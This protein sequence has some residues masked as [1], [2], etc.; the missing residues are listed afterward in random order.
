MSRDTSVPSDE[1]T[2]QKRRQLRREV[3]RILKA[4]LEEDGPGVAVLVIVN[5]NIVLSEGYGYA[6]IGEPDGKITADTVFDLASL[7]KHFTALGILMLIDRTT[8]GNRPDDGSKYWEL[9]F[10][11]SLKSILTELPPW[12][13][14]ITIRHLLN[15]TSGIPDYFALKLQLNEC[16]LDKYF[17]K[18]CEYTGTWYADMEGYE[19][20][21]N[22][23]L[24]L[25]N[26]GVLNLLAE[27]KEATEPD[28]NFVYSNTGYVVLAE[29]IRRVT[30]KS[31]RDFLKEEIFD[32]LKMKDTFVYDETEPGFT[33]HALC[34]RLRD[35]VCRLNHE[36]IECNT[37]FNYIH[38]DGNIHST[39][40]DL[41]KWIQAWNK[42]DDPE[43]ADPKKDDPNKKK[44]DKLIK[45]TTFLKVY[46]PGLTA[47]K[48][49]DWVRR[50]RYRYASGMQLYRYKNKN[51]NSYAIYHGGNWLGFNS[52]MMRGHVALP[53][54]EKTY[55]VTVLVL[56]NYLC[57]WGQI[58][59]PLEIGRKLAELYWPWQKEDRYNVLKYI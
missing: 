4:Y 39:I 54:Q 29:V 25:T 22:K 14:K 55:E 19:K 35:D 10:E 31:L 30:G 59:F 43:I 28:I 17:K 6:R 33:K 52:Y 58:I 46:E 49:E 1:L 56:S 41:A 57:E 11:T 34:Y 27:K 47:E 16:E 7:S 32:R 45:R 44:R 5:D 42:I 18:L 48:G 15:H 53:K 13:E 24:Y 40:N 2:P 8:T 50:K 20:V 12:A 3:K 51:V 23:E 38:G 26:S 36:P 37:I 21:K 9:S